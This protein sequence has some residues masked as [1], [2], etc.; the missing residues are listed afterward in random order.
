M[1]SVRDSNRHVDVAIVLGAKGRC[2]GILDH[3][4]RV[5]VTHRNLKGPSASYLAVEAGGNEAGNSTE[6]LISKVAFP[7]LVYL[8]N[9]RIVTHSTGSQV[10]NRHA[11]RLMCDYSLYSGTFARCLPCQCDR[12]SATSYLATSYVERYLLLTHVSYLLVECRRVVGTQQV[13]F[14]NLCPVYRQ[15][16][17]DSGLYLYQCTVVTKWQMLV[18]YTSGGN[19]AFYCTV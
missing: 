7:P 13:E 14:F 16:E 2:S 1:N 4:G 5:G 12:L 15:W 10:S 8:S 3:A 6:R 17:T 11:V 9:E 19:T 18:R